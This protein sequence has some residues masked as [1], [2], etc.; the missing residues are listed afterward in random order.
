MASKVHFTNNVKDMSEFIPKERIAKEMEGEDPWEYQYVEPVPGES[1]TL[2]DTATRDRFL[3]ERETLHEEYESK[4]LAW[5][6]EADAAK[7]DALKAERNDVAKKLKESYWRLD[8]Y[9]RAR[10]LYDR[11]GII[12]GNGE[13]NYYP[14]K[15]Q[16]A[17]AATAS[18]QLN[19][20]GV[21]DASVPA[22]AAV[23]T[24]TDDVD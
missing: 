9:V 1:A 15:S 16:A 8:P 20:K 22:P 14:E 12:K 7:R 11:V 10:S 18:E 21:S 23:P 17:A 19:E 24:G 4:T 2:K 13:T 5:V 6:R 3:A